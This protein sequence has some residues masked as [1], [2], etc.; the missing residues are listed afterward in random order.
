[1]VNEQSVLVFDVLDVEEKAGMK[2][3]QKV[4]VKTKDVGCSQSAVVRAY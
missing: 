1:M 4:M 2:T 3:S